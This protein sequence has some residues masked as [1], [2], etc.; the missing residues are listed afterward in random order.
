[1][2]VRII[3]ELRKR[4]EAQIEELHEM[5]NKEL[6]DLKSKPTKMNNT[7]SEVKSTLE[8]INSRITE[9]EE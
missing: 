4:T 1:M 9:T 7:I 6:G 8:G 3:P 2:I 5:F